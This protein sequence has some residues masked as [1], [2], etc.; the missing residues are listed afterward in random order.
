MSLQY[1]KYLVLEFTP[2][3]TL[4]YPFPHIPGIVSTDII[5][6]FTYMF[7]QYL[8]HIHPSM[9]F[10]HLFLLYWYQPPQMGPVLSSCFL[11][12]YKKRIGMFS[13]QSFARI[14]K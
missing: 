4:L 12:L 14:P 9:P 1:I 13:Y 10:P 3:T 11:I 7:P 2:S 6:P 8:H 5:F